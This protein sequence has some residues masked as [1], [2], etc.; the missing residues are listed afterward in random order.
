LTESFIEDTLREHF[1]QKKIKKK[2]FKVLR[3]KLTANTDNELSDSDSEDL[4]LLKTQQISRTEDVPNME[5]EDY[6]KC[7]FAGCSQH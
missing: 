2:K 6:F 4:N 3:F 7:S 1:S 5:K